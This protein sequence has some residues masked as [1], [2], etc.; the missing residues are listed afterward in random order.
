M[1]SKVILEQVIKDSKN[2]S[3][4][5][6][7]LYSACSY[8][9]TADIPL[10]PP[11][12]SRFSN[13]KTLGEIA[14][15]R[16]D[17]VIVVT[18]DISQDLSER[19]GKKAQYEEAKRALKTLGKY[20]AGLFIFTD[21]Q[22]QFR[23]SLVY[24]Q[25]M[26]SKIEF[27]NFRRFTYLVDPK[28]TNQTFLKQVGICKYDSLDAIKDAFSVEKV[29][30]QFYKSIASFFERLTG[31][32]DNKPELE[33]PDDLNQDPSILEEFS[34]RLI[35]RIV[36]CWFLKH[37]KSFQGIPLIPKEVLSKGAIKE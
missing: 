27:S 17:K 22:G 31:K 19:S 28:L 9:S 21:P 4:W 35:G 16:L 32:N 14:F 33:L 20:P 6:Q 1:M 5:N 12:D 24:T 23:M 25:Y 2:T 3:I 15:D 29:N 34:I 18:A 7:F 26:G 30:K 10:E 37:K 11:K 8:Y 36:F 13:L